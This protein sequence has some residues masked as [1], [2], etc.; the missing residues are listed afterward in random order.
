MTHCFA[1]LVLRHGQGGDKR[2][3]NMFDIGRIDNNRLAQFIRR[4]R[5]FAENK[6]TCLIAFRCNVFFGDQIH[7]IAERHDESDICS[8]IH[9]CQLIERKRAVKIMHRRPFHIG[10]FAIDRANLLV[11]GSFKFAVH[12]HRIPGRHHHHDIGDFACEFRMIFQKLLIPFKPGENAFA[13]IEPI[14]RENDFPLAS[15]LP[16]HSRVFLDCR[17]Q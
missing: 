6:H 15:Q 17:R 11:D 5:H 7:T 10:I 16:Q 2:I 1:L 4:A 9:T 13:I 8:L 3:F 12:F 14:D